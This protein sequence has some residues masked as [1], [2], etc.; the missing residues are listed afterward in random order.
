MCVEDMNMVY[1]NWVD[2]GLSTL[3]ADGLVGLSPT[4]IGDN[5]PDLFIEKAYDQGTIDE[6]IFSIKFG[7]D[8]ASS[9]ITFG[10]YDT[11]EFAK[12]DLS[13]YPNFTYYSEHYFWAVYMDGV[14][15][16][17]TYN[18]D[19][20]KMLVVDSGSS[21]IL[22]PSSAFE[23]FM[24][25]LNKVS[26][27]WQDEYMQVYCECAGSLYHELPELTFRIGGKNYRVPRESL[28]KPYGFRQNNCYVEVSAL[29]GWEEW[30]LGLTFLENYYAVYD[31]ENMQIG[32]A[33][34]ITSKLGSEGNPQTMLS[35]SALEVST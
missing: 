3:H 15:I 13:W 5:R 29:D 33:E 23:V 31:M 16:G 12:E 21:Y 30:I 17:D 34:S 35:Q 4:K 7:G 18:T 22:M 6:K 32:F 19:I 1:I 27:C 28:Y 25:D 24:D 20:E 14:T 9:M 11:S 26:N 2:D 10:G 8:D